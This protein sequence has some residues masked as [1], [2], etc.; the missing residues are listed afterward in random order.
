MF[1][2]RKLLVADDSVAVQKV[3]D[4]T[5]T[6]EGMQVIAVS[7]GRIALDELERTQPDVV[8]A[9]VFMPEIGGYELCASIKQS[10]RFRHLP[11]MLLVGSFEP[12]DE[13][14]A[15][16]VGADD[17]VTKPF[18]S[19]RD[20]VSR[21]GTLLGAKQDADQSGTQ[22][23]STLGLAGTEPATQPLDQDFTG[24]AIE[25]PPEPKVFV[26][27]AKLGDEISSA[28]EPLTV[29]PG[30]PQEDDHSAHLPAPETVAL[31]T[32]DTKQLPRLE[33]QVAAAP[34]DSAIS[35]QEDTLEIEPIHSQ[36]RD[37][38]FADKI[39]MGAPPMTDQTMPQ[40]VQPNVAVDVLNDSVLDL[41]S[42]GA[43]RGA[44]DEDFFLDLDVEEPLRDTAASEVTETEIRSE[45][46]SVGEIAET[47]PEA[48]GMHEPAA[49]TESWVVIPDIPPA[50]VPVPVVLDEPSSAA[51]SGGGEVGLSAEAIDAIA[52]R[53]VER[54]SE[55]V[56][57]EI[58]WEVVPEL[59]E[60]MIKQRLE[61]QK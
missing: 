54:L 47:T 57:R 8:L 48:L 37:E 42:E 23:Y 35:M 56:V 2:G 11:V 50:D 10:E 41:G 60:L 9:D 20:L 6:D 36:T 12:F 44:V 25:P 3:V 5:F 49:Q 30:L 45:S 18:Q 61:E 21:V 31:Q 38:V 40:S 55:K 16:R 58:A 24:S 17:V 51:L 19:I 27:A 34:P 14:E 28:E 59:A 29:A 7:D 32:A 52:Q 33:S 53:V 26:E 22:Q 13:S 1:A 39:S 43:A 4:L 15:R 46:A